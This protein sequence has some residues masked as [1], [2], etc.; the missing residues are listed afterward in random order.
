MCIPG[1]NREGSNTTSFSIR[2]N[3]L[4]SNQNTPV[5]FR[6][7]NIIAQGKKVNRVINHFWD[8]LHKDY[9]VNLRE[10]YKQNLQNQHQ[11]IR[12][13]QINLEKRNSSRAFKR[14]WWKNELRWGHHRDRFWNDQLRSC[15]RSNLSNVNWMRMLARMWTRM[16]AIMWYDRN[17]MQ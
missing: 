15:F 8:R 1:W 10:T 11:H 4:T 14:A 16:C 13:Y 17:G 5:Q 7:Q 2:Q 6:V 9:V 3:T 12:F